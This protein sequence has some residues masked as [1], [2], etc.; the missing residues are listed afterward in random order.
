M[1]VAPGDHLE[2][3][4]GLVSVERQEA[5][6]IDDEEAGAGEESKPAGKRAHAF[7]V[8]ERGDERGRGRELDLLAPAKGFRGKSH[9]EVGLA[10]PLK[11][12][13]R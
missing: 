10:H 13:G 6:L 2:E 12:R 9:G 1:L 11:A 3:Q 4:V 7:G 5:D 8:S